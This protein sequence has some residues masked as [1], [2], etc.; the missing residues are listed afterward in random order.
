MCPHT[1]LAT[2]REPWGIENTLPWILDMAFRADESRMRT[3]QAAHHMAVLRR[4]A[5]NLLRQEPTAKGG[6]AANRKQAGNPRV[7]GDET[8]LLQVLSQEPHMQDAMAL[9]LDE[10]L[11]RKEM[12]HESC[13]SLLG[14]RKHLP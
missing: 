14:Q 8:Y 13:L 1:L 4:L 10:P 5:L 6:I 11:P 12:R 9:G 2:V 3:G 7:G